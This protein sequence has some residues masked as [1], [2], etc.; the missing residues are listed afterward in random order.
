MRKNEIV[1]VYVRVDEIKG[2]EY[3]MRECE[4]SIAKNRYR[5]KVKMES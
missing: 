1:L 5:E 3:L 4:Y 2:K